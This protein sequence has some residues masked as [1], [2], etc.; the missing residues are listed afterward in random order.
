M[1]LNWKYNLLIALALLLANLAF[2]YL[3][4]LTKAARLFLEQS[5][6][7]V[8]LSKADR[9]KNWLHLDRKGQWRTRDGKLANLVLLARL[10]IPNIDG[11]SYWI[12]VEQQQQW[13]FGNVV[14]TIR[15]ASIKG[16]CNLAIRDREML[17]LH[18]PNADRAEVPVLTVAE[19]SKSQGGPLTRC[20]TDPIII[21]RYDDAEKEYNRGR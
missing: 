9:T 10:T 8:H 3:K 5:L 16:I 11:P 18:N 7:W 12:D 14:K 13:T 4:T 19:Y 6:T 21:Q 2:F 15:A 20:V 17:S 1:R